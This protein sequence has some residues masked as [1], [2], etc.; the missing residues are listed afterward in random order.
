[1]N[2][3]NFSL[4]NTISMNHY[5]LLFLVLF[6]NLVWAQTNESTQEEVCINFDMSLVD[7]E[8]YNNNLVALT[9]HRSD[10]FIHYTAPNGEKLS[11]EFDIYFPTDLEMNARGE[12]FLV[13]LDS[14][15]Q[16]EIGE[17]VETVNT[18]SADSYDASKRFET[19]D[20]P[21]SEVKVFGYN[22]IFYDKSK[23]R[24]SGE[25]VF[26]HFSVLDDMPNVK[27]M[28]YASRD[29]RYDPNDQL[30]QPLIDRRVLVY[31]QPDLGYISNRRSH[32]RAQLNQSSPGRVRMIKESF[33]FDVFR[34]ANCLWLV[35]SKTEELSVYSSRG[36]HLL[37]NSIPSFPDDSKVVHDPVSG[38]P[39]FLQDEKGAWI[40]MIELSQ[41]GSTESVLSMRKGLSKSDLKVR[42]GYLYFR[43]SKGK[44]ETIKRIKLD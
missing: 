22:V 26:S 16:I 20:F 23:P 12:L 33:T 28:D 41:D 38:V 4:T 35:N 6:P 25:N 7:Y 17:F 39:Y 9:K 2:F 15:Y 36:L 19:V 21:D 5:Y 24:P 14:A 42:D 31:G 18:L 3:V 40:E 43:D 44:G 34:N 11:Q 10:Y 8:V 30:D 32:H 13:G 37:T 27:V 29:R 1:M